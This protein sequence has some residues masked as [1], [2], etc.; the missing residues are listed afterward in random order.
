MIKIGLYLEQNQQKPPKAK[1][2]LS[3]VLGGTWGK[4]FGSKGAAGAYSQQKSP[5]NQDGTPASHHPSDPVDGPEISELRAMQPAEASI[6]PG[7]VSIGVQ[8]Q[9]P[10]TGEATGEDA[11]TSQTAASTRPWF[12]NIRSMVLWFK[13]LKSKWE[14]FFF[15]LF[16]MLVL[17]VG[18]IGAYLSYIE[19]VNAILNETVY[20]MPIMVDRGMPVLEVRKYLLRSLAAAGVLGL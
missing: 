9:L 10:D 18:T 14:W 19:A 8:A 4:M 6:V 11:T 12:H 15:T 17:V 1:W 16:V 3:N 13:G 5:K 20:M 7:V 2:G